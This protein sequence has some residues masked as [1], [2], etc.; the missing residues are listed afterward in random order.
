MKPE[1]QGLTVKAVDFEASRKTAELA[2]QLIAE[3]LFDPGVVE[4]GS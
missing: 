2:D 1:G 3:T 4:V